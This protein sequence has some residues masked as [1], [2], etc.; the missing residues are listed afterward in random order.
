MARH[1]RLGALQRG[2][3]SGNKG[4]AHRTLCGGRTAVVSQSMYP[5]DLSLQEARDGKNT[6]Y[7]VAGPDARMT[8]LC[9]STTLVELLH[10]RGYPPYLYLNLWLECS[11]NTPIYLSDLCRH[12]RETRSTAAPAILQ[13]FSFTGAATTPSLKVRS[14]LGRSDVGCKVASNRPCLLIRT[15]S[16][17]V[18]TVKLIASSA[19]NCIGYGLHPS[20]SGHLGTRV[21]LL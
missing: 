3:Y 13:A 6:T 5:V 15:N 19:E 11:K 21:H 14:C 2:V 7:H 10:R 17:A 1:H 8:L 20:S 18:H 16:I 9:R 4:L 12:F